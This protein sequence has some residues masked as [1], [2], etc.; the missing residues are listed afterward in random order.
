MDEVKLEKSKWDAL[1]AAIVVVEKLLQ[2]NY[3]GAIVLHVEYGAIRQVEH[4]S[5]TKIKER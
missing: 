3:L 5:V 4:K 2:Q 1:Q